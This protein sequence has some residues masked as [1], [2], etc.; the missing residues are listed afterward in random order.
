MKKMRT[1][2]MFLPIMDFANGI[3]QGEADINFTLLFLALVASTFGSFVRI[4]YEVQ[5]RKV[6]LKRKV[7]ILVCSICI[8]YLAYSTLT[9]YQKEKWLGPISVVAG[10][11]SVDIIKL[12]IEDLPGMIRDSLRKKLLGEDVKKNQLKIITVFP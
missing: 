2:V 7:F 8:A 4:S 11:I 6:A 3:P 1:L 9:I 10:I 12:F 5:K